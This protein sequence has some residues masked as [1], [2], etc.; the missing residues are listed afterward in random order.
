MD[1]VQISNV[2]T[3][4]YCIGQV[5]LLIFAY[6]RYLSPLAKR[7]RQ[8]RNEQ[9]ALATISTSPKVLEYKRK[10]AEETLFKDVSWAHNHFRAY[11]AS[12]RDARMQGE[13]RAAC[14]VRLRDFLTPQVVIQGA[15]NQRAAEA[16]PGFFLAGGIFGTFLGIVMGLAGVNLTGNATPAA[17]LT[18]V[19]AI[20]E[21]M[22]LAFITSL[23]GIF[24]SVFFSWI[25]RRLLRRLEVEVR[26]LD[27]ATDEIFPCMTEEYYGRLCLENLTA[28]KTQLQT[29]ATDIAVS[30]S[31]QMSNVMKKSVTDELAPLLDKIKDVMEKF[32]MDMDQKN[33]KAVDEMLNKYVSLLSGTFTKEIQE[34]SELIKETGRT[35]ADV[36]AALLQ[37]SDKLS[38]QYRAQEQLVSKTMDAIEFLDDSMD[39]LSSCAV[40]IKEASATLKDTAGALSQTAAALSGIKEL[41]DNLD[42]LT[43]TLTQTIGALMSHIDNMMDRMGSELGKH[44]TDALNSFDGKLAEVLSR[45]SATLAETRDTI[46]EL[47]KLLGV[48]TE[49]INKIENT[50]NNRAGEIDKIIDSTTKVLT[51]N[52]THVQEAASIAAKAAD[53]IGNAIAALE[54]WLAQFEESAKEAIAAAEQ[55]TDL[56][57]NGKDEQTTPNAGEMKTVDNNGDHQAFAATL[58]KSIASMISQLDE[59]RLEL[60]EGALKKLYLT[61]GQ[62]LDT[63][64]EIGVMI[65][66]IETATGNISKGFADLRGTD[67]SKRSGLGGILGR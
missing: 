22:K 13:Q 64:R 49:S 23:I 57:G 62:T 28:M 32:V 45:F 34:I 44:L 27:T 63:T 37:Y 19:K 39:G 60:R 61:Q 51:L 67:P 38:E 48:L 65:R 8:L 66:N 20:V 15:S 17:M 3:W 59:L 41:H 52:V 36:K 53:G 26:E 47:P 56:N 50:L 5:I 40:E 31:D 16:F 7:R 14:C 10:D 25:H 58:E 30:M 29:M 1:W 12:W 43:R 9:S 42:G 11:A 24:S 33:T 18:G 2:T 6:N 54:K 55:L 4:V 46:E 21:G 35:Q